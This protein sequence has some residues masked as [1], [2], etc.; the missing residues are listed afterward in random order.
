MSTEFQRGA[1]AMFDYLITRA[2]HNFHANPETN[3]TNV[4][5]IHEQM[6]ARE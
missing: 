6:G 5:K 2:A 4:V 3:A 1:R